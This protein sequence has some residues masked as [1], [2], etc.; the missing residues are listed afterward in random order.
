MRA[1]YSVGLEGSQGH[2]VTIEARIREEK[3]NVVIVGLPDATLKESRERVMSALHALSLD[4][5][6]TKVTIQLFPSDRQ[7]QGTGFDLAMALAV[8]DR[9]NKKPLPIG[10]ETCVLASINL[11]GALMPFHGLLPSINQAR[12]LGF[13][14]ILVPA[15]PN[16]SLLPKDAIELVELEDITQT[17]QYLNGQPILRLTEPEPLPEQEADDSFTVD[18]SAVRGHQEAKKVLEIA[19]AGGHHVLFTGPPGCGKTMLAEAFHT[20]LPDLTE[21][22]VLDVHNTYLLAKQDRPITKRPPYRHP[23]HSASAMSLI[24]G[25]TYPKPGEISLADRGVL[26]L[27]E[28]GEFSR[29]T[30]DM[31]RQPMESGT[32]EISRVKQAVR[33]PANFILI[34]ATNPCPCG[35]HGSR[36][37]YCS[38]SASQVRN[39]QLKASGPLND[40]LDFI[41]SLKSTGIQDDG[42]GETSKAIRERTTAAR[43]Q[44]QLRYNG[45]Y[46]NGNAPAKL[47]FDSC[48]ATPE[49]MEIINN[50]CYENKWSNRTQLK[51]IR[52]ARTISD[53]TGIESITDESIDFAIHY[54]KLMPTAS[55]NNVAEE[56]GEVTSFEEDE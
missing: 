37:R 26:F 16:Y 14:R 20:I 30:L 4:L 29:K 41:M 11:Y 18:F 55:E 39:Y 49:Q 2:I 5:T 10:P 38:C 28:L 56:G 22:E 42:A 32:V 23:H 27:D 33:Y 43:K 12:K 50:A 9:V 51:L 21:E 47:V 44:Q 54:R 19:A 7:K 13:K 36:Q 3:E 45:K 48:L 15:G 34:S 17:I 46:L 8:I 52:I 40:R 1:I 25:G 35:Y 53:L 24:G 31:L 6:M